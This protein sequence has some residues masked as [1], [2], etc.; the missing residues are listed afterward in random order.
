MWR[1]NKMEN[2]SSLGKSRLVE[3]SSGLGQRSKPEWIPGILSLT[4]STS[5]PRSISGNEKAARNMGN[6][7]NRK[8]NYIRVVV[9]PLCSWCSLPLFSLQQLLLESSRKLVVYYDILTLYSRN[10]CLRFHYLSICLSK[11]HFLS[12]RVA[13]N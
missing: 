6:G 4:L 10:H 9:F 12:P 5:I 11:L 13:L 1:R 3:C 2:W 7:T 8:E